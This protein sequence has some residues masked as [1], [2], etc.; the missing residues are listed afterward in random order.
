MINKVR[1]TK[2]NKGFS[3]VEMLVAIAI[4]SLIAGTVLTVMSLSSNTYS[5][6][7]ADVDIQEEAQLAANSITTML[8][9]CETNVD[10]AAITVNDLDPNE[11]GTASDLTFAQGKNIQI[12][13]DQN[14]ML[15]AYDSATSQLYYLERTYNATTHS[16]PDYDGT[17]AQIL[18]ENITAFTLNLDRFTSEKI[19]CFDLTYELR[20]RSY[21]GSY[22]VNMRND[23][24]VNNGTIYNPA[25]APEI[26]E[27]TM[28]PKTAILVDGVT[29]N[30]TF[31]CKVTKKKGFP[32][33]TMK[34]SID[35]ADAGTC[36]C[37]IDENTGVLTVTGFDNHTANLAKDTFTV[38]G[39]SEFYPAVHDTAIVK[40]KKV[41]G[42]NLTPVSGITTVNPSGLPSTTRQG[43]VKIVPSVLGWNL[44][45]ADQK[46][47]WKLEYRSSSNSPFVLVTDAN[48]AQMTA[49]STQC[50]IKL[51]QNA[52]TDGIFKVTATSTMNTNKSAEYTFGVAYKKGTFQGTFARGVYVNVKDYFLT[53]GY[54]ED[55]VVEVK[56]LELTQVNNF[57]SQTKSL[58]YFKDG[59]LYLDYDAFQ[60]S[61][62]QFLSSFDELTLQIRIQ[63]V[64]QKGETRTETANV[65]FPAVSV[66]KGSP[67]SNY[68][69][70]TKGNSKDVSV[71]LTGYNLTDK[72]QLGCYLD[73]VNVT[74]SGGENLNP[75]IKADFTSALGTDFDYVNKGTFRL[76]AKSSISTYP[77]KGMDLVVALK[78]FYE[79]S[80]RSDTDS[81][82]TYKVYIA[83][84]EG[85]D[86]YIPGVNSGAEFKTGTNIT[87]GPANTLVTI[88]GSGS[89][90]TLSYN[91]NTY[92]F[93]STYNFW[94]KTN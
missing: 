21:S 29:K 78:D 45:S 71:N 81:Y 93:D 16:W 47:T 14:Q 90:Y 59:F 51:G 66:K 18:A 79:Y 52:G 20:G 57:D 9:N 25:G 73:G 42:V 74:A 2:M 26:T 30:Y 75:Y 44:E 77:S 22:Q 48:I 83:N 64:N 61:G 34:Y 69:V 33:T 37:T 82:V 63:Y 24:T 36:G 15:I 86:V 54:Q 46:V 89:N 17:K 76:S 50:E 94:R 28:V 5:R 56:S 23:I 62:Q 10:D 91:N 60:Y 39:T 11:T 85:A 53:T 72:Y 87:T 55:D 3:I 92:I 35:P 65:I 12:C 67:T 40:V 38:I 31:Q 70:L 27:V 7:S 41:T 49:G 1:N 8:M 32:D 6:T 68:I 84:V 58:F 13:N 80:K 88:T 19:I 43:T 4:L